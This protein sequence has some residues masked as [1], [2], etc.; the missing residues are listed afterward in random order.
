ME[1]VGWGRFTFCETDPT[2]EKSNFLQK[3]T[4]CWGFSG[5]V[6]LYFV[7]VYIDIILFGHLFAKSY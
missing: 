1:A 7:D 4:K 6:D 2:G 5:L 3:K